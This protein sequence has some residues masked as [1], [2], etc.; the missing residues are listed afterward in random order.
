MPRRANTW[1]LGSPLYD[2]K[3]TKFRIDAFR[4]ISI[5]MRTMIA[6]RRARTPYRPMQKSI[7]DRSNSYP[8]RIAMR[9]TVI[10]YALKSWFAMP[11]DEV[12]FGSYTGIDVGVSGQPTLPTKDR[13]MT[14]NRA[15]VARTTRTWRAFTSRPPAPPPRP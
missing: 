5:D 8:S 4:I 3:A 6:F 11:F 13:A 15:P 14:R 2:E 7:A 9:R 12:A 10:A 1:P